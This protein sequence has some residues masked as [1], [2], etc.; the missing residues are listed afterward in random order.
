[1]NEKHEHAGDALQRHAAT[2]KRIRKLLGRTQEEL[3]GAL[4]MSLKAVQSYEQ[5]WRGVPARVLIQLLI[6]VALYRKQSGDDVPCWEVRRCEAKQRAGC[7]S[8]TMGSGQF[9]WFIGNKTCR[10][11]GTD[12]GAEIIPC[13]SCP[14]VKRLLAG[15]AK[16]A[17]A[18]PGKAR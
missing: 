1:M 15:G 18:Q 17:R 7:A 3:A 2:V 10:P 6:L 8:Y 9:C 11:A 13:M 12:A 5:G 14:V 4:G 16:A